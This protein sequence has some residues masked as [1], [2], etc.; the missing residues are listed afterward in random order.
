MLD[1]TKKCRVCGGS[2]ADHL[3]SL[4]KTGK[5]HYWIE[6]DLCGGCKA[7]VLSLA[8]IK[9]GTGKTHVTICLARAIAASGKRVLLIDFDL[10]N[11]LSFNL[12]EKE[13]QEKTKRLN[14]ATALND[15]NNNLCDFALPTRKERISLIASTPYLADLRTLAQNRL[16]RMIHTLYGHYDIV[17][18]DCPPTY[19]NIVL[20]AVSA[21][22]YTITPVLNDSFSYNSAHF[23]A[24]VLPR[25]VEGLKAW[26]VLINGFGK[27]FDNAKS[28]RQNDFQKLYERDFPLTP[29]ETWLPW[30]TQIH[31]IVDYDKLLTRAEGN[32]GMIYNPDLHKA[33]SGLAGCFF[34]EDLQIPEAF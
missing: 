22:D 3:Q 9:G 30:T 7:T 5:R 23:F 15:E 29:K 12:L 19:D 33:I 17:I 8:S 18:I 20:N 1:E 16:K 31:W 11:S 6:K 26:F 34:D 14:I 2:E 21:S 28:G 25:D 4:E 32:R 13:T 10:N 24:G 27:R